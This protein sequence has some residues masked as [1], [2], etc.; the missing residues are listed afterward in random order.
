MTKSP[1]KRSEHRQKKGKK[2]DKK[3]SEIYGL[4]KKIRDLEHIVNDKQRTIDTERLR[5]EEQQ[6]KLSHLRNEKSSLLD[7]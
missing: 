7:Q 4:N 1:R 2:D 3:D 6:K 5:Q